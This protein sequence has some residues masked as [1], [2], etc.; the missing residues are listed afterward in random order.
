MGVIYGNIK[1]PLAF[2]DKQNSSKMINGPRYYT[3]IIHLNLFPFWQ[4]LSR[5]TGTGYVYL[6]HNS[7]PPYHAPYTTEASQAL[8]I[9]GYIFALSV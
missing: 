8:E 6:I 2:W 7:A 1:G 4:Y 3:H 5:H 9:L